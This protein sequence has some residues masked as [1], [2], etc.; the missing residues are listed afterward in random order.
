VKLFVTVAK[1]IPQAWH[2]YK[3]KS[4]SGWSIDQVLMD[5]VGG[6]LSIAQLVIDS[7]LE[8]DWSGVTG[9]PVKFGLGNVS[10]LFDIIFMVQHY[11]LYGDTD[12]MAGERLVEGSPLLPSQER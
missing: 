1:Y 7:L 3:A 5:A 8:G 9:N 6:V 4:T 10:L 2:N 12:K 11:L